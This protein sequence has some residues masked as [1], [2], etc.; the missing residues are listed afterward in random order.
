MQ[1][2]RGQV[3]ATQPLA[4]LR[5]ARPH[6]A[7]GGYDYWHQRPDG[8]LVI[9]GSRDAAFDEEQTGV[10]AT[11]ETVQARIE[12]LATRLVG[13][14]L[15]ITHRWAGIW[16]TTP[17]ELPLVGPVPGR[18]G[19]WIAGGYSGH[20]NALGLACGDLV[21]QAILGRQPAELALFDPAR[22]GL[23]VPVQADP[24]S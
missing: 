8:R 14:R 23:R 18:D 4:E 15:R 9:G 22:A 3:L 1:P 2:N 19:V 12:E 20:G 5:Y 21:A 17:D 13:E 24:A 6:Y 11:T 10:E 16:G 7:R